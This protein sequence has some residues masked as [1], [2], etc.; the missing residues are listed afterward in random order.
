[1]FI[2]EV[3]VCVITVCSVHTLYAMVCSSMLYCDLVLENTMKNRIYAYEKLLQFIYTIVSSSPKEKYVC[4]HLMK[5]CT[6]LFA[7]FDTA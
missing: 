6:R 7:T 2:L 4:W 1:M 3:N 5:R